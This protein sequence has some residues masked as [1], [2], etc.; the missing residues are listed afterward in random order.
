MLKVLKVFENEIEA[1][2]SEAVA[3]SACSEASAVAISDRF[4]LFFLQLF[5]L[6]LLQRRI[7]PKRDVI[8]SGLFWYFEAVAVQL[9]TMS[10][11]LPTITS[12][13]TS[14]HS[15]I[16][17]TLNLDSYEFLTPRL[18]IDIL[19]GLSKREKRLIP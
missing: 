5:Q 17:F 6:L 7:V 11:H 13:I 1:E 10:L 9:Q 3:V 4:L 15:H 8:I 12:K 16:T 14:P 2:A 18:N 19:C